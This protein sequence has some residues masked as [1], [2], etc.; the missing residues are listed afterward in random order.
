MSLFD[1]LPSLGDLVG[2]SQSAS[3][4]DVHGE[5]DLL[6]LGSG[7]TSTFVVPQ[8]AQAGLKV[9]STTRDGASGTIKWTFDPDNDDKDSYKTLPDAKTILIVFPLYT[10]DSVRRLVSGYL[11]SRCDDD[12]SFTE[13]TS[14]RSQGVNEFNTR[15][16][17]LGST[18]V[19]NNGPTILQA[20]LSPPEQSYSQSQYSLNKPEFSS[21]LKKH[22]K[23]GKPKPEPTG[24]WRDND[25]EVMP[26]PR[27]LAENYLLSL[28]KTNN[29]IREAP[30]SVTVLL[31]C[32]LWGHGRSVRHFIPRL[33]ANKEA[34]RNL[35][36]IQMI[37]G[38]DV[39]RAVLAARAQ[40]QKANGKR[41]ILTNNRVYDLWEL[42]S[43]FG[44]AGDDGKDHPPTGPFPAI[45]D[46]LLNEPGCPAKSLPRSA[47][48]MY[49]MTGGNS[50]A[51]DGREF[52]HT[53]GLTPDVPWVD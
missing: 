28:S 10:E 22:P 2:T 13:K 5:L 25:S 48:T 53:F 24:P 45:V 1:C 3:R 39:A 7:W 35:G 9:A 23:P 41:W 30:I 36:S 49:E 27:A 32:G 12:E 26:L 42:A 15:F 43:Q 20:P 19:F 17:L 4:Q 51:L 44:S 46:E 8:A 33:P 6:L 47:E 16:V 18:G 21:S 38:R 50:L 37:H 40:F 34:F 14:T 29:A 31:L 52:W 11:H